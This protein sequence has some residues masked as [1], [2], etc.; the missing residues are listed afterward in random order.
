MSLNILYQYFG[1]FEYEI[2]GA[3]VVLYHVNKAIVVIFI[4][5]LT[6]HL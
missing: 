5:Y 4:T 2:L 3:F 1:V 6:V